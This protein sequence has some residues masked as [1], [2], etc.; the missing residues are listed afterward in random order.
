MTFELL[1]KLVMGIG[2]PVIIGACIIIGRKLQILDT[3]QITIEKL[4]NNIKVVVDCLIKAPVEFDNEKIQQYSPLQLTEKGKEWLEEIGF[5]KIFTDN[6]LDFFNLIDAEK[7][8]TKYDVEVS[9]FTSFITLSDKEYFKSIKEY[10][11]QHPKE[12]LQTIG[13]GAGI[14]IRDMYLEKHPEIKE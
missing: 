11:Y 7:P 9:A 14:Y 2:I 8:K 10:L 13:K 6:S 4:K 1:L 5:V 12:N 3:L